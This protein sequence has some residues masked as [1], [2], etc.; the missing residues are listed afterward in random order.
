MF[1]TKCG[2]DN[3]TDARYCYKCGTATAGQDTQGPLQANLGQGWVDVVH[4][5]QQPVDLRSIQAEVGLDRPAV[6]WDALQEV[7]D[8]GG[9]LTADVDV[10]VRP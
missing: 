8:R 6:P 4:A 10:C 5:L 3:S 7:V 2:T 1:C 9:G